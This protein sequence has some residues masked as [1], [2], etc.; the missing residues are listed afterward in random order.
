MPTEK[1]A[2]DIAQ[3]EGPGFN[4][5]D[6]RKQ[7]HCS[8]QDPMMNAKLLYCQGHENQEKPELSHIREN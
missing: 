7:K 1:T 3:Y 2:K 5:Q 6:G 4:P 8:R